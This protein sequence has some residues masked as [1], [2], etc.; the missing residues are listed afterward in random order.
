MLLKINVASNSIKKMAIN[1]MNL[2]MQ[3]ATKI[4]KYA[5]ED[6]KIINAMANFHIHNA[7]LV[8]SA[9]K[10]RINRNFHARNN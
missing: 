7:L 2:K 6:K 4:K 3:V 10:S 1:L 9:S 5:L 8:F